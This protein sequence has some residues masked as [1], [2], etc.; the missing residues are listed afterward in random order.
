MALMIP[1]E[2]LLPL[3]ARYIWWKSPT[4]AVARP[5]RLIAQVMNLGDHGDV[6]SLAT[7]VGDDMLREVI[8]H[9]EAGQFGERAWAYWHYRLGLAKL[10][11][12]PPLP[13]RTFGHSTVLQDQPD[14]W[15]MLVPNAAGDSPQVKVSFFGGIG[16]GRVGLPEP[17]EDGVLV[18]ASLIDLLATKVKVVLQRAEAK[19]YRDIA[20]LLSSGVSLAS[21][22]AAARALFGPSFQPSES[23]RA[24]VFFRDG[25][26]PTLAES[27]KAALVE[28][29]S[30]VRAL[31]EVGI[32]SGR[33]GLQ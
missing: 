31:P 10:E 9:A 20:C 32:C 11:Q 8:G 4:E 15:T 29:A 12:V 30:Q 2:A 33:L 17:T 19:D 5:E 27:E 16:F 24:L 26:L 7:L 14:A 18:V 3:A 21:G 25:D 23:L 1:A 13:R 28:A 6:E 22:L